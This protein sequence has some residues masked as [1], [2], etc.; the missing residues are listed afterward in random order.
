MEFK[1]IDHNGQGKSDTHDGQ[2]QKQS[3]ETHSKGI[4][5]GC[6][7]EVT[8]QSFKDINEAKIAVKLSDQSFSLLV[9]SLPEWTSIMT[10]ETL[11]IDSGSRLLVS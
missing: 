7:I 4:S 8:T 10:M 2:K 9:L 1:S 6:V 11:L 5:P 3:W